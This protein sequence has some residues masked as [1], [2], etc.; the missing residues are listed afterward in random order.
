MR[1]Q[2]YTPSRKSTP[3]SKFALLFQHSLGYQQ[4]VQ[5]NKKATI[6]QKILYYKTLN[7]L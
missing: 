1:S 6:S 2:N 4:S 3:V 7:M 5:Q